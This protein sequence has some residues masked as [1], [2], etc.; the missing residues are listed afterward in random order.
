LPCAAG[1]VT[2][3]NV[4]AG[5]D[6]QG[7]TSEMTFIQ[8]ME[9]ETTR[10]GEMDALL[11]EWIAATEGKRTAVHDVHTQDRDRPGR[12]VDII[13]FPSYDSAM[14]NSQLPETQRISVKM[15]E[16]CDSDVRF[17][18]LDVLRDETLA[19]TSS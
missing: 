14:R 6:D 13:E 7:D 9:Y 4:P 1:G 3:E 5:R 8:I 19:G 16:L 17:L 10:P 12:Y 15:R 18:N 2:L 11:D